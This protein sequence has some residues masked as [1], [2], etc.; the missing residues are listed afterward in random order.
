MQFF[1]TWP[2]AAPEATPLGEVAFTRFLSGGF[3]VRL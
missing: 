1:V 2:R 3:V